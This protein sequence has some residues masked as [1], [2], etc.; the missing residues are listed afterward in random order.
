MPA[1]SEGACAVIDVDSSGTVTSMMLVIEVVEGSALAHG[2]RYR[3]DDYDPGRV[4]T[5]AGLVYAR[6]GC[7]MELE[8]SPWKG[9]NAMSASAAAR[10]AGL[11]HA[12]RSPSQQP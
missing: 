12:L 4:R 7:K 2:K 6:T 11:K 1:S 3:P 9:G 5:S 8:R 10:S